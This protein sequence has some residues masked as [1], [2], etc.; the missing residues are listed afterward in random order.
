M[1][2]A[3]DAR[4]Q[5]YYERRSKQYDT[6]T[7]ME[8]VRIITMP[9]LIRSFASIF[10]ELPH[11]TTR[12]YKSLLKLLGTR[13][14]NNDHRLE[15]YFLSAYAFYRI[16]YLFRAR[17]IEAILKPARYHILLA[18]KLLINNEKIP[19]MNSREMERFCKP[20]IDILCDDDK[21]KKYFNDAIK[22]INI[23]A[24]GNYHR[25]NI[26]TDGFTKNVIEKIKLGK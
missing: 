9:N 24:D 11:S 19:R 16:E 23:V 4:D 26:R 5:R 20:I 6:I 15:M 12:N 14:F 25:D 7:G 3:G 21:Y 17:A 2:P 18:F 8:K 22:I 10:L 1:F 13:I